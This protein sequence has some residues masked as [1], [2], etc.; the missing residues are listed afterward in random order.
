M[1][2][3]KE[4]PLE[5]PHGRV[6]VVDR[7]DQFAVL[8]GAPDAVFHSGSDIIGTDPAYIMFTSGST[9]FPKGAV[10]SSSCHNSRRHVLGARSQS[11]RSCGL[12]EGP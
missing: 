5:T 1:F 9:G 6:F 2:S 8:N 4:A 12:D 10:M 11:S 7:E 3:G